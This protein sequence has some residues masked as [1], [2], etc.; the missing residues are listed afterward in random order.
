M[1]RNTKTLVYLCGILVVM[2]GLSFASVPLYRMFCQITGFDGTTM[3]AKLAP[4]LITERLV[5]IRLNTDVN[6]N[7]EWSFQPSIRATSIKIG[8]VGQAVF[9]VKNNGEEAVVGTSTYNVTPEKAG[10]YFNKLQCFCFTKHLL[11]PGESAEFPVQFFVDPA[12]AD[13]PKLADVKTITLSYTF[14]KAADQNLAAV[15]SN[16]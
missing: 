13:D 5:E 10:Q 8:E 15:Q 12:M 6:P 11:K 14:F 2:G 3:V 9:Y 16:P 4:S 1:Q 7:L